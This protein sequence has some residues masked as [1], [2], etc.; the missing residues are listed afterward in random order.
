MIQHNN[1]QDNLNVT[2]MPF[3]E[4]L[5]SNMRVDIAVSKEG[6]LWLL[7]DKPIE[8]YLAWLEYD[9]TDRRMTLISDIGQIQDLG[10]QPSTFISDL[11]LKSVNARLLLVQNKEILNVSNIPIV[12]LQ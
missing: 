8:H 2:G 5:T 3:I 9:H 11:I 1:A 4:E 10:M 6:D 12:I 7:H